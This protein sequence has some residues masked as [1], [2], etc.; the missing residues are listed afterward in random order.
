MFQV[1]NSLMM[2]VMISGLLGKWIFPALLITFATDYSLVRAF[3]QESLKETG[4][5]Q[6]QNFFPL[7][8]AV[9]ALW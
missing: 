1:V 5:I 7:K 8:S 4:G 3:I 9:F 6:Q 2:W